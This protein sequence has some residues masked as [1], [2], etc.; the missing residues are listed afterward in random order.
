MAYAEGMV[1]AHWGET[2]AQIAYMGGWG[3]E[4]DWEK[5]AHLEWACV[6]KGQCEMKWER[7]RGS[8]T[9]SLPIHSVI[10]VTS[11]NRRKVTQ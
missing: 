2:R 4:G 10:Q 8:V 9:Q 11:R 3:A 7:V 1:W 6:N 5:L